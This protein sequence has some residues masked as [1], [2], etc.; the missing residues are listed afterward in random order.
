M[1]LLGA[2]LAAVCQQ[3]ASKTV[4][5][6][7]GSGNPDGLLKTWLT[8]RRRTP[9]FFRQKMAVHKKRYLKFVVFLLPVVLG[10]SA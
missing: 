10:E 8:D 1:F 3:Q 5:F 9:S 4:S 6:L 7:P 2:S